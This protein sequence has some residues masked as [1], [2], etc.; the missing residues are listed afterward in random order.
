MELELISFTLVLL[1]ATSQPLQ[2]CL[3]MPVCVKVRH[4]PPHLTAVSE[5]VKPLSLN[6]PINS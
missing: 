2:T 5:L 1:F 3:I 4:L 6:Q